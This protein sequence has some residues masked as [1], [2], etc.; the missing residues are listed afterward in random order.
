MILK[1]WNTEA[2]RWKTIDNI[3]TIDYYGL[4][5]YGAIE[6]DDG[7]KRKPQ[8]VFYTKSI[9]EILYS[10]ELFQGMIAFI[11]ND[12]GKTIERIN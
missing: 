12:E 10:V 9:D 2:N 1:Y 3:D 8:E 5:W 4:E 7:V 11:L 6:K